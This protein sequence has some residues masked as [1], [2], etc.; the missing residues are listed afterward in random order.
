MAGKYV[1]A[2]GARRPPS[3]G[4]LS[5]RWVR[6]DATPGLRAVDRGFSATAPRQTAD[7]APGSR[8]YGGCMSSEK[9]L[10][11]VIA[12]GGVA[13]L[14]LTMAL[15]DLAEERALITLVAPERD[16]ELK[17]LRTAEPF[18]RDHVRRYPLADIARRFTAHVRTAGVA[19]VDADRHVV[20]LTD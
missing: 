19:R 4:L 5:P 7:G 15:R 17:P 20:R 2:N 16:F 18:S 11:V 3:A 13:A 1:D 12:G 14:E 10:H 9:P 8:P 6:P